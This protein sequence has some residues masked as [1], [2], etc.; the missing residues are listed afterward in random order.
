MNRGARPRVDALDYTRFVAAM[1]VVF[2]HYLAHG[3]PGITATPLAGVATYGYLGVDVFFLLSGFVIAMS[4]HGRT[5]R[6]FAAARLT[7]LYPAF[8]VSLLLTTLVLT[9]WGDR[10]GRSVTVGQ[11]LANATM[12]PE[13]FDSAP[14]D[15][16]YWTLLYELKFYVLVIFLLA[17]GQG[18]RLGTLM[19]WWAIGMFGLMIAAPRLAAE[20]VYAGGFYSYFATGAVIAD[21]RRRGRW[22]P[23]HVAALFCGAALMT[24][25]A[26]RDPGPVG[27]FDVDV[28]AGASLLFVGVLILFFLAVT[29]PRAA[30]TRLPLAAG[31]GSLT[32]PLYLL[33]WG[34]GSVA[35]S[36]VISDGNRWIV[37]PAVIVGMLGLSAAV[38]RIGSWSGWRALF[39]VMVRLPPA[40]KE[41][42]P[43]LGPAGPSHAIA[44]AAR[45]DTSETASSS[46][47]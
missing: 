21:V 33:H 18:R 43:P 9:V 3:Q 16:V 2:Y 25:R 1:A 20:T 35:M 30:A 47:Y 32:Y 38:H 6:E 19:A 11:V 15:V 27:V 31:V 24:A 42:R 22:T 5:A 7:R 10:I 8:W 13:L 4:G 41:D 28:S 45:A 36:F 34:I 40:H 23:V 26:Q 17:L 12:A 46:A 37:Y 29:H 44:G 14:V 39:R